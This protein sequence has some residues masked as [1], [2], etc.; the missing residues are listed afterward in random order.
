MA[1]P[2]PKAARN[3]LQKQRENAFLVN[4]PRSL[5]RGLDR[6][7]PPLS[8]SGRGRHLTLCSETPA[9]RNPKSFK[10]FGPLSLKESDPAARI[11]PAPDTV[12]PS[13]NERD[14]LQ[15]GMA[16]ELGTEHGLKVHRSSVGRVLH[17]LGLSRRK[18]AD[19]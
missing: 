16:A 17:R 3:W 8:I 13:C 2:T 18:L 7:A 12:I 1:D 15:L 10:D 14:S 4:Q 9:A 5:W 6:T 19:A 11:D